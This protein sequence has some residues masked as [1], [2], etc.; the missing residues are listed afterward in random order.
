MSPLAATLST[1]FAWVPAR[2][3][4]LVPFD[5]SH[6]VGGLQRAPRTSKSYCTYCIALHL[7]SE[8]ARSLSN[9]VSVLFF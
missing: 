5:C 6:F 2:M 8:D 3:A 9:L 7:W 4:S 1:R